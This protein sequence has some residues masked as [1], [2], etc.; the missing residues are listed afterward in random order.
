MTDKDI[1]RIAME[2]SAVDIGADAGDFLLNEN[3]VVSY[4]P[5]EGVKSYYNKPISC[6]FIS[7][8]NNIVVGAADE[9]RDIVKDYIDGF[10]FYHCFE[11]P[12][13]RWLNE[14]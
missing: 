5:G 3:V 6:N 9:I 12:N 1:L 8:G 10:I 4:D 14:R 11:T 7:Y 2:Q 13:M